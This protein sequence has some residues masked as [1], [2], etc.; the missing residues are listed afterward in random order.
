MQIVEQECLKFEKDNKLV[1]ETVRVLFSRLPR[2]TEPSE[3]LTKVVVLNQ[4]YSARVLSIHIQPL[5]NHIVKCGIDQL[6]H[7]GSGQAVECITN[8]P[9][10]HKYYS[11]ATK[12]CSWH[13]PDAYP[14]WDW[15]VDAALW[16]YRK[17]YAFH[18]F[19]H[20]DLGSYRSLVE[21]I[22]VFRTHFGLSSLNFKKID[23][24][25]WITGGR[26][27]QRTP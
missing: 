1:E 24:F 16:F 13:G 11:F 26:L 12:Y 19:R 17:K 25:L 3:V 22:K 5:T 14:M 27:L 10:T 21:I 23:Q 20:K 4:L 8:C 15:N 18:N 2:N 7:R 6:L 9:E